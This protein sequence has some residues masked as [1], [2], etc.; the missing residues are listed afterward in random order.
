MFRSFTDLKG[1]T[2][3]ANNVKSYNIW[4]AEETEGFFL[5]PAC[6]HFWRSKLSAGPHSNF[7]FGFILMK[8]VSAEDCTGLLIGRESDSA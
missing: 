5:A 1:I 2:I 7:S 8:Y 4:L 3:S 6:L